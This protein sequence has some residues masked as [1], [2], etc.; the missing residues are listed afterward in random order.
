MVSLNSAATW[1]RNGSQATAA[2]FHAELVA[3]A[4]TKCTASIP[5]S[6]RIS[7]AEDTVVLGFIPMVLKG[8][9]VDHQRQHRQAL[10]RNADLET[11]PLRGRLRILHFYQLS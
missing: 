2:G 1:N 8:R 11:E 9:S 7:A 6:S 10:V 3:R 4:K 5:Q